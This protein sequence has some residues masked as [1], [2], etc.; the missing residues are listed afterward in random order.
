MH[1]VELCGV[2]AASVCP[3]R[4]CC[5]YYCCCCFLSSVC[6]NR[7]VCPPVHGRPVELICARCSGLIS[8]LSSIE[9]DHVRWS[10]HL[11]I[12][13][14]LRCSN[15]VSERN[16]RSQHPLPARSTPTCFQTTQRERG[17]CVALSGPRDT[18]TDPNAPGLCVSCE[19]R[20]KSLKTLI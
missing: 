9:H 16:S 12:P 14:M 3:C 11:L 8:W 15:T 2:M 10:H 7:H 6:S 4:T 20:V 1:I 17:W 19:N 5:L 13:R 18:W